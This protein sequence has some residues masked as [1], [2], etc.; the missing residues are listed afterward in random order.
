MSEEEIDKLET[1]QEGVEPLKRAQQTMHEAIV[2]TEEARRRLR[3]QQEDEE[4]SNY[5][6]RITK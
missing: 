5:R 4:D 6:R 3:I 2:D 1:A